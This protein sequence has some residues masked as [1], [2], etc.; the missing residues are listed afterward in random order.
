[1]TDPGEDAN[2]TPFQ[3]SVELLP[4]LPELTDMTL[5]CE[6]DELVVTMRP[7]ERG[8]LITWAQVI[9]LPLAVACVFVAG[10]LI[11]WVK[12]S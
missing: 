12:Q 10:G 6:G 1:M 11:N 3:Q 2:S 4:P 9:G 7:A 5:A 8:R